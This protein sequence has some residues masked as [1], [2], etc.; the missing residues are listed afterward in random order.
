[1]K[2]GWGIRIALPGGAIDKRR[3][4]T[5]AERLQRQLQKLHTF[6]WVM[7]NLSH[8]STGGLY[9]HSVPILKRLDAGSAP[10]HEGFR[11]LVRGLRKQG[12]RVLVYFAAQGP[13]LA[14]VRAEQRTRLQTARPAF[15]ERI[16]SV[17]SSWDQFLQTEGLTH[18][19]G[20]EEIIRQLS[21]DFGDDLDGW[22]FDHGHWGAAEPY[23]A[24]ARAGNE[25]TAIAW[26]G[27]HRV[28]RYGEQ[29]ERVWMLSVGA[30]GVDYT[31]GHITPRS[32]KEPWWEGNEL[33]LAQIAREECAESPPLV[34]H[35]FL[36]AQSYWRGGPPFPA[37]TAVGW[38]R[39]VIK[40]GGA[41]TWAAALEPPEFST[42]TIAASSFKVLV[43]ID[44]AV[45]QVRGGKRKPP[46]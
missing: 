24:A 31:D 16:Q 6:D 35:V 1:M 19:E 22:W 4:D 10:D 26:N 12:K 21:R 37:E 11:N 17:E 14:M 5:E 3:F 36:P 38:T 42:F 45:A 18:Q 46:D 43:A 44:D 40:N 13:S 20:T 29:Q 8:P 25:N 34:P 23:I 7:L 41:I 32:W 30:N 2:G 9:T 15:L 28:E 27:K 33:M 39:K